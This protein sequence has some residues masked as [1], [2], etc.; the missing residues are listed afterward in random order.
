MTHQPSGGIL[1]YDL[2]FP[3]TPTMEHS[4]TTIPMPR[5]HDAFAGAPEHASY[6][7]LRKALTIKAQRV[8][9]LVAI[10]RS[11][12]SQLD[13]AKQLAKVARMEAERRRAIS[14]A[15]TVFVL[16]H[17][18]RHPTWSATDAHLAM[19]EHVQQAAYSTT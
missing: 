16:E 14:A 5:V 13:A 10:T 4:W 3:S 6:Q 19:Q 17:W 15:Q 2:E 7:Q 1:N 12:E 11:L 18:N 9:T 8:E